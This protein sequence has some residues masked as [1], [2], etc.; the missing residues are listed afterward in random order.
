MSKKP[1][2]TQYWESLNITCQTEAQVL[3]WKYISTYIKD[4]KATPYFMNK[5]IPTQKRPSTK[6]SFPQRSVCEAL[7]RARELGVSSLLPSIA[8]NSS[9]YEEKIHSRTITWDP[10]TAVA[11]SWTWN[12]VYHWAVP[13][14]CLSNNFL[15]QLA[16]KNPHCI[17]NLPSQTGYQQRKL[18]CQLQ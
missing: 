11:K 10:F 12:L 3:I 7:C 16:E 6:T 9:R 4:L 1:F 17:Y 18:G 15:I 2:H 8:V 13:F 14:P 5:K